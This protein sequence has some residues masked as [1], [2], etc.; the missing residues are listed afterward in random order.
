MRAVNSF[1]TAA[2]ADAAAGAFNA[3]RPNCPH[4]IEI[5]FTDLLHGSERV[6]VVSQ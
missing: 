2:A 3:L 1:R 5:K 4:Q 6:S